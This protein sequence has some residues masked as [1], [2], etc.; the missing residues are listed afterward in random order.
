MRIRPGRNL[1]CCAGG[2][3]AASLLA[4]FWPPVA[5]LIVATMVAA[6][7]GMAYDYRRLDQHFGRVTIERTMPAVIGRDVPFVVAL[8]VCN[9]SSQPLSGELRDDVPADAVPVFRQ[10][11][12]RVAG[13]GQGLGFKVG[14]GKKLSPVA[15]IQLV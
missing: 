11:L 15:V 13:R 9:D 10:H 14:E 2:L 6:A 4:F 12:K 8:K 1:V 7:A 3:V 5:W